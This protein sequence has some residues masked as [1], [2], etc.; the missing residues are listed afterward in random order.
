MQFPFNI[1]GTS[2]AAAAGSLLLFIG[3]TAGGW[4]VASAQMDSTPGDQR[5]CFVEADSLS[6]IIGTWTPA[7]WAVHRGGTLVSM[8]S[9]APPA[10]YAGMMRWYRE[11]KPIE[12]RRGRYTRVGQPVVKLKADL[13]PLEPY[14]GMPLF[15]AARDSSPVPDVIFAP[16]RPGCEFQAYQYEGPRQI[17]E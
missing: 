9:V 8:D 6:E 7:G 14:G 17:R 5:S 3:L 15:R 13:A 2:T 4:G 12:L 16:I 11:D 10:R 1:I